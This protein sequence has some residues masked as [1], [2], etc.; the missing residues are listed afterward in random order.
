M[1]HDASATP[2][3]DEYGPDLT[4][5]GS[6]AVGEGEMG[7]A[8]SAWLAERA[9]PVAMRWA[10][11]VAQRQ[12]GMDPRWQSLLQQFFDLTLQIMPKC[13]G[14]L[15]TQF[16]PIFRRLAELYGSVGA[17]RG[18][19]A[20]EIIEEVQLLRELLIRQ[21]FS[22]PPAAR[23]PSLLLREVVR[24]NRLVDREVTYASVG[25]T[26]AM[27]FALFQGSGAPAQLDE[28]VLSEIEEQLREIRDECDALDDLQARNNRPGPSA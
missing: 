2:T 22:D 4:G 13:L 12:D 10:G 18:L 24:L 3:I 1:I 8:F 19:A 7:P 5:P 26:D 15:R 25:H 28:T 11:G 20:G 9:A 17:M 21:L 16:L 27:F 14:P 6:V 23:S